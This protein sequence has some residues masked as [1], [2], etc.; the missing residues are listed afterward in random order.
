MAY[1]QVETMRPLLNAKR[2]LTTLEARGG[3][4]A[5][6]PKSLILCLDGGLFAWASKRWRAQRVRGFFGRTVL[7]RSHKG[8]TALVGNFGVG[9]PAIAVLAEDW[10][11]HSV[12]QIILI[13]VAATLSPSIQAGEIITLNAAIGHDAVSP[14]YAPATA[15]HMASPSLL[16]RLTQQPAL[17]K[18]ARALTISTPYRTNQQT[19][20]NALAHNATLLEMETAALFA[21]GAN[22]GIKT[23]AV[24]VAADAFTHHQWQPMPN[25]HSIQ[26]SLRI[27][28]QNILKLM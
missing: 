21:V 9:A 19:I 7:P 3:L 25:W 12:E 8:R 15:L 13:G 6:Q 16:R 23:A 5:C 17:Q 10:T 14:A 4:P 18:Q 26:Q 28:Y 11:T 1:E 24:V 2:R 27:A 20:A 22:I